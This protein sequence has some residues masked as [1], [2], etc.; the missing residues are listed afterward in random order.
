MSSIAADMHQFS[1]VTWDMVHS[2]SAKDPAICM[3][4]KCVKDG[5]PSKKCEMSP[6]ISEF[7]EYRHGLSL[8]DVVVLYND[9]IV[10]PANLCTYSLEYV[11]FQHDLEGGVYLHSIFTGCHSRC[12]G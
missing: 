12:H 5:F 6:E 9:S 1:A 2:E 11:F 10:V 8:S 7:W 3:L 4:A